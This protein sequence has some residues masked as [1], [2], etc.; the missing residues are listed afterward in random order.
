[1]KEVLLQYGE[2]FCGPGG[3]AL[4]AVS[5]QAESNGATYRIKHRWA[6]DCDYDSCQTYTR[7]IS[8]RDPSSVICQDVRSLKIGKLTR[9]DVFAYGFPCNDFSIVGE[10]KGFAG[11]FGP[12]Y[13]YGVRVLDM[14]KPKLFVAENV[15]GLQSA[16]NGKALKK[17][18]R[19]LR[20]AGDGYN[21]TVH[22]YRAEDYGVPQ[23]RHRIIMV[24]VQS[25]LGVWFQVPKPTH[26][27]KH[28]SAKNA[29]EKPPISNIPSEGS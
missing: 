17:I 3:L 29:L 26:T 11:E 22:R 6:N 9:I 25:K 23:T 28:I 15:G 8:P 1:M 27:N 24:G 21:I 13:S 12:L 2:L 18:I 20:N 10:Q 7:N 4:G 16:N 5:S 19:D 14:L